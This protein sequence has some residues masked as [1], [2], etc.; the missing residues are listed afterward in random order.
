MTPPP[1]DTVLPAPEDLENDLEN[2][3]E[4]GSEDGPASVR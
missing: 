2:D 3:L 1:D 4:I